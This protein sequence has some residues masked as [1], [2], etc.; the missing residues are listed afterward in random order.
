MGALA[1]AIQLLG[2]V[3]ALISAGQDVV[4]LVNSGNAALKAMQA[5]KR[6]PTDAEWAALDTQIGALRRALH[7]A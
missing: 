1:Y 2:E 6:D 4:T 3:P 5:E 7:A